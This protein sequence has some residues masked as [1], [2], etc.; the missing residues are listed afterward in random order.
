[1]CINP[2][3][4]IEEKSEEVEEGIQAEEITPDYT[5]DDIQALSDRTILYLR[6]RIETISGVGVIQSNISRVKGTY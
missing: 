2:D 6:K 1:M 5:E 4:N 3:L